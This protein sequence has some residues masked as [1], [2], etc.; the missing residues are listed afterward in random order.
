MQL[1]KAALLASGMNPVAHHPPGVISHS[2][3]RG[4]VIDR[5]T[6]NALDAVLPAVNGKTVDRFGKRYLVGADQPRHTGT[7]LLIEGQ[8]T[9][10]YPYGEAPQDTSLTLLAQDYTV[11][12]WTG[13][14]TIGGVTATPGNPQTFTA[15]AG[16]NAITVSGD[17][18]QVQVEAGLIATSY[19]PTSG[20][21]ATRATEAA[22]VDGDGYS[23][24]IDKMSDKGACL[25]R[26]VVDSNGNVC[27]PTGNNLIGDV[28]AWNA[29][30]LDGLGS[31][32]DETANSITANGVGQY[33]AALKAILTNGK[34]YI[35]EG[36]A[37]GVSGTFR[38]MGESS[39]YGY[40]EISEDGPFVGEFFSSGTNFQISARTAGA[41]ATFTNLKVEEVQAEGTLSFGVRMKYDKADSPGVSQGLI[42]CSDNYASLPW[43]NG[44]GV[45]YCE[46]S[47]GN[48]FTNTYDFVADEYCDVRFCWG[49][50]KACL[51]VNGVAGTEGDF[52]GALADVSDRLRLADNLQYGIEIGPYMTFKS[53]KE[54]A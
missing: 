44:T 29:Y 6:G 2:D 26:L 45:F 51:Y 24:D 31:W 53:V 50:G 52:S 35:V 1:R 43:L 8:A 48:Y 17:A 30:V 10:V 3:L 23:F 22:S 9:N 39:G 11:Q 27:T 49:G 54:A 37:S 36:N 47:A 16:S 19:I 38:F 25:G 21:T 28:E 13:S 40:V 18:E 42:T 4:D 32:S 33:S 41:S 7:G 15:T 12:V 34:R 5:V 46:D 20:A 14:A